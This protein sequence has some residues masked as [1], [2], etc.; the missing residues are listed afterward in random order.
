[1]SKPHL[2]SLNHDRT[3]SHAQNV[4]KCLHRKE[5]PNMHADSHERPKVVACQGEFPRN[6]NLGVNFC[7]YTGLLPPFP[8]PPDAPVQLHR[9]CHS[10]R[11]QDKMGTQTES[12]YPTSRCGCLGICLVPGGYRKI[13]RQRPGSLLLSSTMGSTLACVTG[14][15]PSDVKANGRSRGCLRSLKVRHWCPVN[16][17]RKSE[18]WLHL[19]RAHSGRHFRLRY[20]VLSSPSCPD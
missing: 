20:S 11:L 17:E 2:R 14:G 15:V 9:T 13:K 1:M 7:Q 10:L 8:T 5:H 3:R 4:R 6:C 19:W 12:E 16:I 18:C